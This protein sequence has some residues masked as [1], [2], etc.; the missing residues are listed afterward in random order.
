MRKV[1][2]LLLAFAATATPVGAADPAPLSIGN[3]VQVLVDDHLVETMPGLV[4]R[5]NPLG[6]HSANPVFPP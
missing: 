6:K 5:V 2:G 4:R 1:I 3:E